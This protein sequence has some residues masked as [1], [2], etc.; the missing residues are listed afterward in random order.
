MRC[1]ACFVVLSTNTRSDISLLFARCP[2]SGEGGAARAVRSTMST[3]KETEDLELTELDDSD[4]ELRL[5]TDQG[6]LFLVR[7]R[8]RY[9]G[10][11]SSHSVDKC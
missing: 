7:V 3:S 6:T 2:R 9:S 11:R 10:N 8:A 1:L 4:L 5:T